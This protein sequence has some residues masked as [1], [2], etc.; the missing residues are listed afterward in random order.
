[1]SISEME[2]LDIKDATKC[3]H[4]VNCPDRYLY[5][6]FT[7]PPDLGMNKIHYKTFI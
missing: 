2:T 3:K 5:R 1:M 7:L 4:A 6:S